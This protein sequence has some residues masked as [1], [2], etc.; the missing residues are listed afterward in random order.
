MSRSASCLA[1]WGNQARFVPRSTKANQ[2]LLQIHYFLEGVSVSRKTFVGARATH[3]NGSKLNPRK[4]QVLVHP[5]ARA[6]H[7][8]VTLFLTTT[9]TRITEGVDPPCKVA[10]RLHERGVDVVV[11]GQKLLESVL[12]TL[13]VTNSAPLL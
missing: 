5:F 7:F 9:A 13:G 2:L 11:D 4:P 1:L 8:G 6:S 3:G 10:F 12:A